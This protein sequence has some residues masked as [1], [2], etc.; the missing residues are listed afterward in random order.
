MST[1]ESHRY[2]ITSGINIYHFWHA[3]YAGGA[4]LEIKEHQNMCI[5]D[6]EKMLHKLRR[7]RMHL[8]ESG[9]QFRFSCLI[10]LLCSNTAKSN[11]CWL[12]HNFC[13]MLEVEYRQEMITRCFFLSSP[14][15]V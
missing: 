7:Q 13:Y 4:Q 5:K 6:V 2:F 8:V 14:G 15:T 10:V 1:V 12:Q 11:S 3:S 9:K